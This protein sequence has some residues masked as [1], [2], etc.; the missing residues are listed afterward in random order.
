M[1]RPDPTDGQDHSAVPPHEMREALESARRRLVEDRVRDEQPR[2]A[3]E[4]RAALREAF[5]P[6]ALRDRDQPATP[7]E[8]L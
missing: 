1:D 5:E 4:L 8:H 2:S 6:A 7:E 3:S